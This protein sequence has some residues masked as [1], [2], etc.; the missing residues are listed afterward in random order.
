M[1][2]LIK[3]LVNELREKADALEQG[4]SYINKDSCYKVLEQLNILENGDTIMSA[5]D[6]E[7]YLGISHTTF[8]SYVSSGI[9]PKGR[10]LFQKV[11]AKFWY[12]SELKI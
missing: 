4:T 10:L 3:L 7:D 11:K 9:L 6:C 8:K 12:K 1:T 5:A 2:D